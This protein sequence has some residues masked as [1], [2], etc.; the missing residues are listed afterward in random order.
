MDD[1]ASDVPILRGLK[2]K[3]NLESLATLGGKVRPVA[4]RKF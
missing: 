1:A 2:K 4:A 3:G